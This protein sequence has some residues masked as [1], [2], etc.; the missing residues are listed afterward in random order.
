MNRT[1]GA[2]WL[3]TLLSAWAQAPSGRWDGTVQMDGKNYP[4]SLHFDSKGGQFS[5]VLVNGGSKTPPA[6]ASFQEG[7]VLL[8]F[9][10]AGGTLKA[11]LQGGELKGSFAFSARE[12]AFVAAAYCTCGN[13]GVA[14]PEIMG[15]WALSPHGWRVTVRREGEDTLATVHRPDGDIGPLTGRFDGL[16]F[17]LHYFDGTRAAQLELEPRKDGGLDAIWA[18]PGKPAVKGTAT[19][20]TGAPR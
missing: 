8:D 15:G 20:A 6:S 2:V 11:V 4:V 9:G 5:G 18:E 1:A 13:E 10:P 3:L 14:G 12:H 17:L 19:R 7:K 16:G